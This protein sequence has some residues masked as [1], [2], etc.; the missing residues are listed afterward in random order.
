M[1]KLTLP[2]IFEADTETSL[3]LDELYCDL[4][5][6]SDPMQH[7]Y[8]LRHSLVQVGAL[9]AP[10]KF[11]LDVEFNQKE[12]LYINELKKTLDSPYKKQMSLRMGKT[13]DTQPSMGNNGNV[14]IELGTMT[15]KTHQPK[16]RTKLE[17]RFKI[18]P[19]KLATEAV[20][21][22]STRDGY[23]TLEQ[24]DLDLDDQTGRSLGRGSPE[25]MSSD[26]SPNSGCIKLDDDVS[27]GGKVYG[28]N[29]MFKDTFDKEDKENT[30][31]NKGGVKRESTATRIRQPLASDISLRDLTI[32]GL[33]TTKN[34]KTTGYDTQGTIQTEPDDFKSNDDEIKLSNYY[35]NSKKNNNSMGMSTG[36]STKNEDPILGAGNDKGKKVGPLNIFQF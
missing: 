32:S 2:M 25:E 23:F 7:F 30:S 16:P 6:I 9:H 22:Q 18:A 12:E 20:G 36:L 17:E 1:V 21:K 13:E 8:S 34:L 19:L 26:K 31:N 29:L 11:Q 27:P 3:V 33:T 14:K 10:A 24:Q 5:S 4:I 15:T 28:N 35:L